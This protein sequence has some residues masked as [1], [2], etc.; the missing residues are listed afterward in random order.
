MKI[1]RRAFRQFWKFLV[2]PLCV[3]TKRLTLGGLGKFMMY[4]E[5]VARPLKMKQTS[6]AP[7]ELL[8]SSLALLAN[9]IQ[10]RKIRLTFGNADSIVHTPRLTSLISSLFV[11]R[12]EMKLL[13]RKNCIPSAFV[14]ILNETGI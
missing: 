12:H 11:A 13:I 4:V 14:I 7:L 6:F 1:S 10:R 3:N 8:T 5:I 2:L 9:I